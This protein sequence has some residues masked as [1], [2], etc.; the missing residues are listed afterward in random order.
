MFR[1]K[2][3][4]GA[5][6]EAVRLAKLHEI[7]KTIN[8]ELDREKLLQLIMDI[9]IDLTDA[10]RGFV[11]LSQDGEDQVVVARNMDREEVQRPSFKI[12]H[13]IVQQ[14]RESGQ[15][16]LSRDAQAEKELSAYRSV[17]DLKL[18]SI[19]CVPFRLKDRVIGVL[20]L[21]HRFQKGNFGEDD[22]KVLEMFADQ[23]AI[24]IENVRL[25]EENRRA[26]AELARM[27]R[28]L[29]AQVETQE[30]E[31]DEI[32][33]KLRHQDQ[34]S[35]FQYDYR[36]IVGNS[37]AMQSIFRV[38]DRV[39]DSDL[40]VVLLGESG[41]GKEL[42]ARMIHDNS[43]RKSGPYVSE[44][45]GAIPES[46]MEAE[47]FGYVK[48]AFT[49]ADRDK[50]G[51]LE[52]AH[53]GTFFLD[54]IGEM[55]LALQK[56]LLRA[57]QEGEFRKVGG[58]DTLRVDVRFLSA[59][60]RDL[61]QMVED[62][63]F[64]ADLY[65]RLKGVVI[66]LPPLRDRREDIPLLVE[67]FLDQAAANSDKPVSTMAPDVLEMLV[68]HD[69]PGNVRELENEVRCMATLAQGAIDQALVES[70]LGDRRSRRG[71]SDTGEAGFDGRTLAEIEEVAIRRALRLTNGK[72]SEAARMLG[73]ARRTFYD[74][75]KKMG[76]T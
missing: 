9:V 20:Y 30:R 70:V 33:E 5:D 36:H 60:N 26:N 8:S 74:K 64:R 11:I 49:G 35:P 65:Y 57:I 6:P 54:E 1:Q 63:E 37:K 17:S 52:L 51:L 41:T 56:K 34:E 39:I 21:D 73:I 31:I 38:L 4:K 59:T 3:E 62:G 25:H 76:E 24:A 48:G 71:S 22:I 10:E 43:S 40:P 44:N 75:L 13:S 50:P 68:Q 46:L 15:G 67:H 27:N 19:L 32:R 45:C 42:V 69:W 58:G 55:D 66:E 14:V 16:V 23:A 61:A 12:S 7:S 53:G 47:I 29:Q 18:R 72:K 28:D 2:P